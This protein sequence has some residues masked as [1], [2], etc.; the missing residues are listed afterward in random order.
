MV[1]IFTK[2]RF[3]ISLM[4]CN[5]FY[6]DKYVTNGYIPFGWLLS[7]IKLHV[8][9]IKY[10]KQHWCKSY[11]FQQDHGMMQILDTP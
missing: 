11:G 3:N 6:N 5:D 1:S 10:V 8:I 4:I 2:N 7:K 9:H